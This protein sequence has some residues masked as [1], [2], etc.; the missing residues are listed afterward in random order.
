MKDILFYQ[1]E[2]K[3]IIPSSYNYVTLNMRMHYLSTLVE[4]LFI[5]FFFKAASQ[6]RKIVSF[7]LIDIT[8]FFNQP[9]EKKVTFITQASDC[10]HWEESFNDCKSWTRYADV[11]A[12]NRVI[13]HERDRI[14][15]RLAG[16]TTF[17]FW[18]NLFL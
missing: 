3:V 13:Q 4:L 18:L 2:Q 15:T 17:V 9:W 8:V 7:F 6:K 14:K 11:E 5:A 16:M 1:L 10:S 12:A